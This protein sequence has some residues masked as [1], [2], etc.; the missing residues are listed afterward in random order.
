MATL[1]E[2]RDYCLRYLA[3]SAASGSEPDDIDHLVNQVIREIICTRHNWPSMEAVYTSTNG[4]VANEDLYDF[5]NAAYFKDCL[6]VL[7]NDSAT[8][9]TI[10]K[11]LD[12]VTERLQ[13]WEFLSSTDTGTPTRWSRFGK[14][15]RFRPIPDVA[16]IDLMTI[17]WEYPA[18]LAGDS[19]SNDFTDN[20]ASLVESWVIAKAL[21]YYR[22]NEAAQ[23]MRG[24]AEAEL[25]EAIRQDKIISAPSA[26]TMAPSRIAGVPRSNTAS[27]KWRRSRYSILG[28]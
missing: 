26:Q 22:E 4:T 1:S 28:G 15:I 13:R 23:F 12:E 10:W 3:R 19:D 20:Y 18:V 9:T 14:K 5:P 8:S 21:G 25:A 16:T 24:L 6:L 7:V 17:V 2:I 11:P 27:W